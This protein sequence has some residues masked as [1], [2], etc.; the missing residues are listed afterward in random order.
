MLSRKRRRRRRPERGTGSACAAAHRDPDRRDERA[1]PRRHVSIAAAE[2]PGPWSRRRRA[3]YG[4]HHRDPD[5]G[6]QQHLA[7]R[8]GADRVVE[9]ALLDPD[10]HRV[11][12]DGARRSCRRSPAPVVVDDRLVDDRRAPVALACALRVDRVRRVPCANRRTVGQARGDG[13]S[14][15][16]AAPARRRRSR[17]RG[18]RRDPRVGAVGGAAERERAHRSVAALAALWPALGWRSCGS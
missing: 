10:D 2:R 18:A 5:T 12:A 9:Q 13:D 6:R 17:S 15:G 14:L 11:G 4:D 7:R 3:P 1:G 8:G 16:P